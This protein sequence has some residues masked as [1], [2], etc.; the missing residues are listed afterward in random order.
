M[1]NNLA[2]EKQ[3][4]EEAG[5]KVLAPLKNFPDTEEW[6]KSFKG[7]YL[8]TETTGFNLLEDEIIQLSIATFFFD[9]DGNISE[10]FMIYN[11]MQEP[12]VKEIPEKIQRMTGINSDD[13]KGKRIEWDKVNDIVED[14]DICIA[15]NAKCRHLLQYH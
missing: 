8:D 3:K 13:V 9:R 2:E 10:P 4:L 12:L 14:A 11:E 7:I 6:E 5:Y 15:H 1:D